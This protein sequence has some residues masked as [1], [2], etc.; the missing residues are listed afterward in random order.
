MITKY[1][2]NAILH[3]V[4]ISLIISY[5]DEMKYEIGKSNHQD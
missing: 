5:N 1:A 4:R 3:H 2:L